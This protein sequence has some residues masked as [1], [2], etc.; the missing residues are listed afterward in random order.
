MRADFRA[1]FIKKSSLFWWKSL[2]LL[3]STEYP[4]FPPVS[5]SIS[6]IF[7]A[8]SAHFHV[9]T[10]FSS[11]PF[12]SFQILPLPDLPKEGPEPIFRRIQTIHTHY[13]EGLKE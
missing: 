13:P 8:L 11:H 12:K 4:P 9:S 10:S 5:T 1:F 2:P 7:P 3:I 6:T